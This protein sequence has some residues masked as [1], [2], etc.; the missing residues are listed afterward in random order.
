MGAST[1]KPYPGS[2]LSGFGRGCNQR[3]IKPA[4]AGPQTIPEKLLE[5]PSVC[6]RQRRYAPAAG[7]QKI[8][9]NTSIYLRNQ[10]FRGSS[11]AEAGDTFCSCIVTWTKRGPITPELPVGLPVVVIAA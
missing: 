4:L 8:M 5:S 9:I 2:P 3:E 11:S 1:A 6:R 10:R 7:R